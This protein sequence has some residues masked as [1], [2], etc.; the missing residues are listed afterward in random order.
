MAP[1]IQEQPEYDDEDD[2]EEVVPVK[3]SGGFLFGNK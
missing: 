3:A 1:P 2:D